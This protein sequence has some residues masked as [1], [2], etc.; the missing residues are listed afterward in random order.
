MQI[1]DVKAYPLAIA[2]P[3][4]TWTAHERSTDATLILVE[5]RTDAGHCC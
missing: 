3:Q 1:T 5:V 4:P 2:R